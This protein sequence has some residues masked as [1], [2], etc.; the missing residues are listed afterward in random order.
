MTP[1]ANSKEPKEEQTQTK[2]KTK[3]FIEEKILIAIMMAASLCLAAGL[4]F[5]IF[6]EKKSAQTVTKKIPKVEK[7][8]I[9]YD[10][11]EPEI[12]K[13]DEY[14]RITI[15]DLENYGDPGQPVLP[16]KSVNIL[17]PQ[18]KKVAKI[19]ITPEGENMLPGF[20][21][22]EPGQESQP[23]SVADHEVPATQ[24]DHEIYSSPSV[25]P[26]NNY[27]GNSVQKLRGYSILTMNLNPV[28]YYPLEGE[29][30]YY[31]QIDITLE[32]KTDKDK[33]ADPLFRK[34]PKDKKLVKEKV[35]NSA[36]T[37]KYIN[38]KSPKSDLLP[39]HSVHEYVIITNQALETS[40]QPL[41]DAKTAKGL[42][43][44]IVVTTEYIYAN[45]AGV[46]NQE[47]IRNFIKDAYLNWQTEYVLLGGDTEVVPVRGAYVRYYNY[48]EYDA[49]ADLYYAALDGTWNDDGDE[50][51][52]EITDNADLVAEVFVGRAPVE[53]VGEVNNFIS[54]TLAYSSSSLADYQTLLIGE[55]LDATNWAGDRKDEVIEYHPSQYNFTTLYDRDGTFSTP[56]VIDN[57]NSGIYHSVDHLGHANYLTVMGLNR[58]EVDSLTNTEYYLVYSM[59]CHSAAF[60]NND[61]IAEHFVFADHAA[62]AYIGNSRYGWYNS[63]TGR[64]SSALF[65]REFYKAIYYDGERQVGK[66]LQASK[67]K[68][69]SSSQYYSSTNR[70]TYF[71]LNLLGDPDVDMLADAAVGK[72]IRLTWPVGGV[73]DVI[74]TVT[75]DSFNQ[76]KLEYASATDPEVWTEVGTYDTAVVN[77]VLG[78][79]DTTVLNDGTYYLRLTVTD[80]VG[81]TYVD[82]YFGDIEVD[83]INI[84][85]PGTNEVFGG[86]SSSIS[87]VGNVVGDNFVNYI[88]EHG[89]GEIPL[90]WSSE[91]VILTNG[92]TLPVS[93][94]VLATWDS[95][96][97]T[98]PGLYTIR[99]TAQYSTGDPEVET[100]VVYIDQYQDGWPVGVEGQGFAFVGS[101]VM[102]DLD[103]VSGEETVVATSDGKIYAWH[104]DG[105]LVAN[106]PI[107]TGEWFDS[108][109]TVGDINQDGTLEIVIATTSG[110][111][112][113]SIVYVWDYQGNAL[114]NWPKVTENIGFSAE[115]VLE[116]VA[117]DSTLEIIAVG[118]NFG[119]NRTVF[120]W[121]YLGNALA[122][123]P[124]AAAEASF[125]FASLAVGDINGDTEKEVIMTNYEKIYV[126]NSDGTLLAGWPQTVEGT[127]GSTPVLADLDQDGDLEIILNTK[128]WI[129]D[130]Y[131]YKL[132]VWHHN[133]EIMNG[134][135]QYTDFDLVRSAAV[136][137]IDN[138][139]DLEIV[140]QGVQDYIYAFH[141]NGTTVAG[142]PIYIEGYSNSPIALFDV[143]SDGDLE[144]IF[145]RRSNADFT[146]S[147]Y[148]VQYDGSFLTGWPRLLPND[149]R[150]SP[151]LTDLD[152]DGDVELVAVVPPGSNKVIVWDLAG[153]Y[154]PI[155]WGWP[156]LAFQPEHTGVYARCSD[157]SVF[158]QCSTDTLYCNNGKL[159][160]FCGKCGYTCP[161]ESPICNADG[162][163]G[164]PSCADGTPFG[165]CSATRPIYCQEG[166]LV[167]DCAVCGCPDGQSS[168]LAGGTC[169]AQCQDNIDND[170][171]TFTDYPLDLGCENILD[172]SELNLAIACDDGID[173]DADGLTDYPDDPGCEGIDDNNEVDPATCGD[174]ICEGVG[175]EDCTTCELDCPISITYDTTC[176]DGICNQGED[177]HNCPGDCPG[178]FKGKPSGRYCCG[179]DTCDAVQCGADC[180]SL[181]TPIEDCCGD[182]SCAGS[183]TS[184]MCEVDCGPPPVCD[185]NIVEEGEVCD[186]TATGTPCD[187]ECQAD[188]TCPDTG[189]I[190]QPRVCKCD[191]VCDPKKETHETC[192]W[193]CP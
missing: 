56:A 28:E 61:A 126:W 17:I 65:D 177:C 72:I 148:I 192:P 141:H 49:P 88:I 139:G 178:V 52:G 89:F 18:G 13:V 54:K 164:T 110:M 172:D 66:A 191:G 116:D 146:S 33:T 87:I 182:G 129:G 120:I 130:H 99:L 37:E 10:F 51:W 59:G 90:I 107:A 43:G 34:L 161:P 40:W 159:M 134:W 105:T 175:R 73:F 75:G 149:L 46:D 189:C 24:P 171:D 118:D 78:Q 115:M 109:P 38:K 29:I 102:A 150:S 114:T 121:D 117:G 104:A 22:I 132:Y 14:D 167:N 144:V 133:G 93:N 6:Y 100:V 35:D 185:N 96:T 152:N 169:V 71:V 173:N 44:P 63:G 9:T 48:I 91:N 41:L 143:D 79:W 156:Q 174:G 176:G 153:S 160:D 8:S 111:T 42:V 187:G 16:Y 58:T 45:Y 154:P 113:S 53:T 27:S 98:E 80:T 94:D 147:L 101:P 2:V 74:G 97:V 145:V 57:L 95:S 83:N 7:I 122:G 31:D 193:D 157:G 26:E 70:W 60:D 162:T 131:E 86:T 4:F 55:Q 138:D 127:Y 125:G 124:Q 69:V 68:F 186:G 119:T 190:E 168:C 135:P 82:Q 181:G 112:G 142:W 19:S 1:K 23:M 77:D 85:A 47:K 123:W 81:S 67:E 151:A 5:G 136:G 163:C 106:F 128:W 180:G 158:S 155:N 25:Y 76:Y 184:L 137:D 170:G 39:F 62:Y 165:E 12:E 15:T 179:V 11:S 84:T 30:Y 50:M 64:A 36:V 166:E 20:F 188:C 21:T 32:L 92:G 108:S 140:Y 3:V 183:E 103:G